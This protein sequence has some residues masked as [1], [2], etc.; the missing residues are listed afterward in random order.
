MLA[1][2]TT[3]ILVI[4][5]VL[6]GIMALGFAALLLLAWRMGK[7]IEA[8]MRAD[9]QVP[10]RA[11]LQVAAGFIN[12]R[13]PAYS[14]GEAGCKVSLKRDWNIENREG[15]LKRAEILDSMMIAN[16]AWH[17]TRLV[18]MLRIAAGAGYL[19]P[20]EAWER[21]TEPGRRIQAAYKSWDEVAIAM[22]AALD[23]QKGEW[24]AKAREAFNGN[25]A[26][27]RKVHFRGVE[28]GTKF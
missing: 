4:V 16:P 9:A 25:L 14:H 19:T 26:Q 7:S 2:V 13:D 20:E 18:N 15:V 23:E 24:V 10:A 28:Y 6:V 1:S 17:G 5:G 8:S 22:Q 21:A 11:W 3:V 12:Y 27:L